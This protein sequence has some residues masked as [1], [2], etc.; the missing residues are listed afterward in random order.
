MHTSNPRSDQRPDR[1]Q[2]LCSI[3][4]LLISGRTKAIIYDH[5]SC[6]GS[7]RGDI[8]IAEVLIF[9]PESFLRIFEVCRVISECGCMSEI[10]GLKPQEGRLRPNDCNEQDE[11]CHDANQNP[12]N[13]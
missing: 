1:D 12:M 5:L 3:I 7:F 6:H 8:V 13:L 4:R 11:G 10:I 9:F 2:L